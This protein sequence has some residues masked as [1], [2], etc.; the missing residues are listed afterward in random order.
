[1]LAASDGPMLD[2]QPSEAGSNIL[3]FPAALDGAVPSYNVLAVPAE[4]KFMPEAIAGIY[5]G[6]FAKWNDPAITGSNP[7]VKLP[8][9]GTVSVHRSDGSVSVALIQ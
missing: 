6:K 5:L 4:L 2:E 3:H 8:A 1:M 7:G 9:E